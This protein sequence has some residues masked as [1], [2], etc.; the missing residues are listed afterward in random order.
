MGILVGES[1]P[2]SVDCKR[3]PQA[4]SGDGSQDVR[5]NERFLLDLR[6]CNRSQKSA[7]DPLFSHHL[8]WFTLSG[9]VVSLGH[10]LPADPAVDRRLHFY[11]SFH[12]QLAAGLPFLCYKI[13]PASGTQLCSQR[14]WDPLFRKRLEG[15]STTEGISGVVW[16]LPR[17]RFKLAGSGK[18]VIHLY[19]SK[20]RVQKKTKIE[21]Y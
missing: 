7:R 18:F 11:P 15:E 19:G 6:C 14:W 9:T 8:C 17:A 4:G 2:F 3:G 10:L 21:A 1:F 5:R 16:H 13:F 12:K 20:G